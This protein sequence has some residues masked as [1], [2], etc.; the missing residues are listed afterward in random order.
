MYTQYQQYN[1]YQNQNQQKPSSSSLE[2]SAQGMEWNGTSW[3][4]VQSQSQS[5][6]QSQS[7]SYN[8]NNN[9]MSNTPNTFSSQ[10]QTSPPPNQ[11]KIPPH[12]VQ[13]YTQYYH[14]WTKRAKELSRSLTLHNGNNNHEIENNHQWAKYYAEESSRAAHHFHQ[15]PQ[16]TSAPFTL[17]PAPPKNSND[18]NNNNQ[19]I[20]VSTTAMSSS[21]TT[22]NS[23]GSVTRYVKRNMERHEVQSDAEM[24]KRVQAEI[25]KQIAVAIQEG[26]FQSKNWDE[27]PLIDLGLQPPPP[28]PQEQQP[29]NGHHN[30]EHSSSVGGNH[31]QRNY[32]NMNN[33]TVEENIKNPRSS[34]DYSKNGPT[35]SV[36]TD[37]VGSADSNSYYG[38]SSHNVNA[39]LQRINYHNP[40]SPFSPSFSSSSSQY[41]NNDK[42]KH[43]KNNKRRHHQQHQEGEFTALDSYGPSS[44][45]SSKNKKYRR[46]STNSK[47]IR[48]GGLDVSQ[49][50]LNKRANRFSGHGGIHEVNDRCFVGGIDDDSHGKYMGKSLIGG[51]NV[52]LDAVDYEL[53]KVKGT[54][55]TCEKEYLRLTAPPRPELVRPIGILQQHL[56]NLQHEYFGVLYNSDC[57]NVKNDEY[58]LE[59][60]TILQERMRTPQD[61]WDIIDGNNDGDS[62]SSLKCRHRHDYMWFC[63]QLKAIRQDCTV[64]HIQGDFA[65]EV[66]ETHAR[67][68]LQE[69]D[70]NE[71]NQCQTQLKELYKMSPFTGSSKNMKVVEMDSFDN[72]NCSSFVW[73]NQEEFIAY[74]LLYYVYLSTNERYSGGS[75]DMFHIMLSLTVK[76]RNH[77]AIQHAL[78]VREAIAFSDYF[79]FFRLHKKS[80]NLGFFLTALLVPNLRLRGLKRIAKAYRPSVGLGFCLQQLGFCDGNSDG[81]SNIDECVINDCT[82][83]GKTWL[84]RCGCVIDGSK[85]M[86]KESEIHAPDTTKNSL[87]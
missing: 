19:S 58:D 45:S 28:P 56:R 34:S 86:T 23:A 52:T 71:Y 39:S 20:S 79:R 36:S 14:G 44:S 12:P 83:E 10:L 72:K 30:Y 18:T 68:A 9:S 27:V 42:T 49:Q 11:V 5:Q 40:L 80:P 61:K 73:K 74:R 75:S 13:T 21:S 41:S 1:Q 2:R 65:V 70:L 82:E 57:S 22:G 51:T 69:G 62:P 60:S 48:N 87:I 29:Y 76:E 67:I 37:Y 78:Q 17:P 50:T 6:L 54:S 8:N 35:S 16:A 38:P 24:K 59:V 77:P 81:R 66:Y 64:Q 7:Q 53:M 55:S 43:S 25:E 4:Q 47:A 3:I 85:F 46:M 31:Y 32:N 84:V 33:N 63:S 26:K 15:H